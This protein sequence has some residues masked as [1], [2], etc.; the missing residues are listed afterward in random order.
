MSLGHNAA[1]SPSRPPDSPADPGSLPSPGLLGGTSLNALLPLS[2]AVAQWIRTQANYD[3]APSPIE[4]SRFLLPPVNLNTGFDSPNALSNDGGLGSSSIGCNPSS[5]Y[6]LSPS[7]GN[8]DALSGTHRQ[9]GPKLSPD[10]T[11]PGSAVSYFPS[12]SPQ[13]SRAVTKSPETPLAIVQYKPSGNTEETRSKKRPA[14]EEVTPQGIASQTLRHVSMEDENG[15]VQ[16]T[17]M[18]F[19]ERTKRRA[20]FTKEKRQQTA[21]ARKEGVCGRCKNSKRQVLES[22]FLFWPVLIL[23]SSQCDLAQQESLYVS[24]TTCTHTRLYK[25][26]ARNPCFKSTLADILFFRSGEFTILPPVALAS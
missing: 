8:H 4:S 10:V 26:A 20:V 18:T 3:L 1:Y 21:R 24:C 16:G 13:R 6:A 22:D 17:M 15:Q 12:P 11:V 19:G 7:P 9:L 5:Q 2:P 25:R 14:L 23:T